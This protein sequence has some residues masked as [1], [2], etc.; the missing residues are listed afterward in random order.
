MLV[1]DSSFLSGYEN[2]N[3]I[4]DIVNAIVIQKSA[5]LFPANHPKTVSGH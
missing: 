1:V 2:A 4:L 3:T 5:L